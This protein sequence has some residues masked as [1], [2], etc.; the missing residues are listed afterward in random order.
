[1]PQATAEKLAVFENH[2]VDALVFPYVPTFAQPIKNPLYT[3]DDPTFVN[4][5]APV[6]ATMSGYSSV[7]FPSIVVPMGFGTQGLPMNIT[8]FGK[9]YDEKNYV[10]GD[11]D[12]HRGPRL[13]VEH[14]V[15]RQTSETADFFGLSDRGRLLPGLRADVNVIDFDRLRL[16]K[17]ELVHDMPACGR[18]FVQRVDGYEATLAAGIPIFERGEH[19]G[20]MP[21]RLV[22]A[23][24][25]R[26]A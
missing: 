2:G 5:D 25:R 21:G 13:P 12:R 10:A 26:A 6:P 1:M 16:H 4:S 19:T 8:F 24:S 22:R 15:K 9:P 7:G 11:H 3:I 14:L 23:V 18:R 20:A 17:L